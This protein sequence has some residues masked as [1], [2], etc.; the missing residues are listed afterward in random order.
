MI[1]F[2]CDYEL[3][4][5]DTES[6]RL[7][8]TKPWELVSLGLYSSTRGPIV[9]H[10]V[11]PRHDPTDVWEKH[12]G[13]ASGVLETAPT[14][15]SACR[16]VRAHTFGRDVLVWNAEH[17]I[18]VMPFLAEK[19]ESGRPLHNLQDMMVRSAPLL[20][21]WNRHFAGYQWPSL[22][23]AARELGLNFTIGGHHTAM[24]D[25][26]MLIQVWNRLEAQP[27]H[28]NRLPASK[29]PLLLVGQTDPSL[30]F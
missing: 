6:R 22:A 15:A 23:D 29:P 12:L 11:R 26:Q 30:P 3:L 18:R 28:L 10:P 16:A 20:R 14:Y 5:L 8:P 21:P 2:D 27:I 24:S 4:S 7:D 13:L 17:E 1:E 25:A 9:C 19:A